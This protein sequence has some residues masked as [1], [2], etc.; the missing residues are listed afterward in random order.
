[1]SNTDPVLSSIDLLKLK[2]DPNSTPIPDSPSLALAVAAVA[3]VGEVGECI[4]P[5]VS[6]LDSWMYHLSS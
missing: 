5:R 1:M 6:C 3:E 2:L 4:P